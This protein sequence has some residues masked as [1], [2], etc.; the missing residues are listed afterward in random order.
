[1]FINLARVSDLNVTRTKPPWKQI[2]PHTIV[3][4][5][6]PPGSFRQ[7][8]SKTLTK[9][10]P[11]TRLSIHPDTYHLFYV[12]GSVLKHSVVLYVSVY[13]VLEGG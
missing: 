8:A 7:H 13:L 4:I 2:F 9:F 11:G 5:T 12:Y 10:F 1:M 3:E 6:R